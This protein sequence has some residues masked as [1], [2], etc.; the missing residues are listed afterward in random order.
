MKIYIYILLL[1]LLN[2]KRN[3]FYEKSSCLGNGQYLFSTT[4]DSKS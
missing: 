2:S 4:L 1:V 3:L